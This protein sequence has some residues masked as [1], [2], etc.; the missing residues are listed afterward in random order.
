MRG[1]TLSWLIAA[2]LTVVAAT[3]AA[4]PCAG[5]GDVDDSSPFCASVDWMKNRQ[6]TLGC[7]DGT[8]YCPGDPVS[9]LAMAAFMRRLGLAL[10]PATVGREQTISTAD[11]AV[12]VITCTTPAMTAVNY[13]RSAN[14]SG[15]VYIADPYF[16]NAGYILD[17]LY[18][19]DGFGTYNYANASGTP[20]V[21][22]GGL[23]A[24]AGSFITRDIVIPAGATVTY[25]LQIRRGFGTANITTGLCNLRAEAFNRN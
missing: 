20:I 14:V 25:G 21:M 1:A 17:P 22:P 6:V 12:P 18:S 13:D 23:G 19:F 4:A 2:S 24:V 3:A 5:F 7:G 8:N 16:S 9:R 10:T 15:T 11:L